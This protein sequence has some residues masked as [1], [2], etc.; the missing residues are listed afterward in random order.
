MS[1]VQGSQQGIVQYPGVRGNWKL[2]PPRPER[3]E[4][5]LQKCGA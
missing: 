3:K 5:G 4:G 1:R 2:L